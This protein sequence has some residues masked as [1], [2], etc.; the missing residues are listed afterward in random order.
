MGSEVTY[1]HIGSWVAGVYH[2]T[3]LARLPVLAR[4]L[5]LQYDTSKAFFHCAKQMI[6]ISR[7]LHTDLWGQ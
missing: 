6:Y 3:L 1:L 5:A 2:R 7:R 4:E